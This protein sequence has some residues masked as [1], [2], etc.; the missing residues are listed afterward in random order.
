MAYPCDLASNRDLLGHKSGRGGAYT[1]GHTSEDELQTNKEMTNHGTYSR[2]RRSGMSTSGNVNTANALFGNDHG[3]EANLNDGSVS[4]SALN[5]LTQP[6]G[7]DRLIS[8]KYGVQYV[9]PL[10]IIYK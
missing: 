8:N 6:I 10:T 3:F 1:H 5:G 2:S 9:Q 4:K 7:N